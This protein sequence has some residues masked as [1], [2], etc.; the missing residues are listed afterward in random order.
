M[1]DK[2]DVPKAATEISNIVDAGDIEKAQIRLSTEYIRMQPDEFKDLVNQMTSGESGKSKMYLSGQNL[3]VDNWTFP[4]PDSTLFVKPVK[5]SS[6]PE[7]RFL[8]LCSRSP[9]DKQVIAT[10][11]L[12]GAYNDLPKDEG[13]LLMNNAEDLYS[14]H[15]DARATKVYGGKNGDTSP[16]DPLL[17][18]K[19]RDLDKDGIDE[20]ADV[21]M[22]YDEG[23]YRGSPPTQLD[24]FDPPKPEPA[25]PAGYQP[26]VP[27]PFEP[28][29]GSDLDKNVQPKSRASQMIRKD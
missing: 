4:V 22:V 7:A 13:K 10:K 9:V 28:R 29:S 27:P 23:G 5:P 12:I 11:G 24:L 14:R 21:R 2:I 25:Y 16:A 17:S 1:A 8:D 20:L 6:T 19:F 18:M 3:N 15:V 26:F